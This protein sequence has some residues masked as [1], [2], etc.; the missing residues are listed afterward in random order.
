M[1]AWL[2]ETQGPGF[3]L[4]RHF[5]RRFF[6]SESV[7]TTGN[8]ATVLAGLLPMVAQLFFLMI[9]P[10]RRKYQML[11]ASP[12][13]DV[14]RNAVLADE[15]WL[16]TLMAGAVGLL[17]AIRWRSL[18]PELQDIRALAA[19]PVTPLQIFI[20]KAQALL[21]V[22]AGGL[23]ILNT[24]PT[25]LL[26][27]LSSGAYALPR[28]LLE[29]VFAH[30]LASAVAG[31]TTFATLLALHGVLA[32]CLP[33]RL[34]SRVEGLV[35]AALVALMLATIVLSFSASLDVMT[36]ALREGWATW[37]PPF[38]FVGVYQQIA[39]IADTHTMQMAS[40]A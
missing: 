24:L 27:A 14:F 10:L 7:T 12:S 17:T 37:L 26:P 22:A 40:K 18:L 25:V 1:K 28:P 15:L 32:Q 9:L 21:L 5:L 38:W 35:Q 30:A 16:I 3:E 11:S 8:T 19:L 2:E 29:R 13:P 33:P 39:G 34:F 20:A 31:A 36:R 23:I 4:F 6:A